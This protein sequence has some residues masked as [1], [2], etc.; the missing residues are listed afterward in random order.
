MRRTGAAVLLIAVLAVAFVTWLTLGRGEYVRVE[1]PGP[2]PRTVADIL[3]EAVP[4]P[5]R[6]SGG[7]EAQPGP[8]T[9]RGGEVAVLRGL[10]RWMDSP[11]P[12]SGGFRASW[13]SGHR[14]EDADVLVRGGHWEVPVDR[15]PDSLLVHE[16]TLDG[17]RAWASPTILAVEPGQVV[18]IVAE[19][20]TPEAVRLFDRHSGRELETATLIDVFRLQTQ[21]GATLEPHPGPQRNQLAVLQRPAPIPTWELSHHPVRMI[22]SPGYSW[23]E[24]LTIDRRP[25]PTTVLLAPAG[26]L[27]IV[28]RG[29]S[30]DSGVL[31]LWGRGSAGSGTPTY[32]FPITMGTQ[33]ITLS[34]VVADAYTAK[35]SLRSPES[36]RCAA[37][38]WP[39]VLASGE[40]VTIDLSDS[41]MAPSEGLVEVAG[42]IL[43]PPE[44]GEAGSLSVS[45]E[46]L[47]VPCRTPVQRVVSPALSR[48]STDAIE[49]IEWSPV[50]VAPGRY[51]VTVS[52]P[53][54]ATE[55]VVPDVAFFLIEFELPE[56]LEVEVQFRDRSSGKSVEVEW[57]SHASA[58]STSPEEL[59]PL[60]LSA[61][62]RAPQG[63]YTLLR[64][65]RGWTT[66]TVSSKT[67]GDGHVDTLVQ[68]SGPHVVGLD[69]TQRMRLTSTAFGE[70]TGLPVDLWTGIEVLDL[71]GGRSVLRSVEALDSMIEGRS[72]SVELLVTARQTYV[73]RLLGHSLRVEAEELEAGP[74]A[75]DLT[76]TY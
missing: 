24:L 41:A 60:P 73:V 48:S 59:D 28:A 62:L 29:E 38:E 33:P 21:V 18:T 75:L 22:G 39:F 74:L 35:W 2:A 23:A 49:L 58:G 20:A 32:G 19:R 61:N 43:C 12:P 56:L 40:T 31:E 10:V 1:A 47:D 57:F 42:A 6:A 26:D 4:E 8:S 72:S 46:P 67:H 55:V 51:R 68:A 50:S 36:V 44:S 13:A 27:R 52:P 69:A 64:V 53:L 17:G 71:G 45:L 3:P 14:R 65:P 66:W 5:L 76:A 16:M 37:R 25:R 15:L 54:F 70:P 11:N 7:V 9:E 30:M 34:G 63:E